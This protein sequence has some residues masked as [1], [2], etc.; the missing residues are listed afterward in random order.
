MADA[1]PVLR[2]TGVR[3]G[4]GDVEVLRGV[5]LDVGAGELVALVGANGAGKTT[6]LR[7]VSGLIRPTAD[8]RATAP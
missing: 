1:E 5:S 2:L 8:R 7:T 6:T 3:A 4:Y